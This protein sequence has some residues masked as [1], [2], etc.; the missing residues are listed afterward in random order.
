MCVCYFF[1]IYMCI[2]LHMIVSTNLSEIRNGLYSESTQ[3]LLFI[4]GTLTVRLQSKI[5]KQFL[6]SRQNKAFM[7]KNVLYQF[8]RLTPR[9]VIQGGRAAGR[10]RVINSLITGARQCHFDV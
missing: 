6:D 7:I 4:L 8:E 3:R 10:G 5:K 2:V 1:R 9:P